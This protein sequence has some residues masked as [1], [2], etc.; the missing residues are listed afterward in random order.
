M[1]PMRP[2]IPASFFGMILGIGG[3]SN[4]WRVAAK[5]W[6][7]PVIIADAIAVL[8]LAIWFTLLCFYIGKWMWARA[9]ALDE[10]HHPVQ[11]FFVVLLAV[12]TMIAGIAIRPVLPLVSTIML[13]AG[14][15]FQLGFTVW[16]VGNIW[17]G[18]R[19]PETTTPVLYMPTVGGGFVSAMALSTLGRPDWAILF[20]G[21]AF[22]S[23]LVMEA[24]ILQRFITQP[25]M[26]LPMRSSMGIHLAPPSVCCVAYLG[27]TQAAPDLLAQGLIGYGVLHMLVA[28]RLIPWLRQQS[29]GPGFWAYSFGISALPLAALR[30]VERGQAGAIAEL[31]PVL[32]ALANLFIA[33]FFIGTVRLLIQ[34][35]LLPVLAAAPKA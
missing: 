11:S 29:F 8:A 7:F 20:F 10:L 32:F 25:A 33:A 19:A 31:A 14:V 34:G 27:L 9:A 22:V 35:K 23:W 5:L 30:C 13:Y 2:I 4:G 17:Q 6:N 1:Q 3:L 15:A 24:I 16:G 21:A 18:G 12:A 28:S 26:P